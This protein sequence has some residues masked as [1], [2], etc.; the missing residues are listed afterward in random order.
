MVCWLCKKDASLL[1]YYGGVCDEC[2]VLL[3]ILS[4]L[5]RYKSLEVYRRMNDIILR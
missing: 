5:D 3:D 1:V 2:K 4:R